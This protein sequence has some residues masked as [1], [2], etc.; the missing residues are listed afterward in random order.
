MNTPIYKKTVLKNGLRYL[1]VPMKSSETVLAMVLVGTGA[2]FETKEQNG[3]AHFLEH[4]CFKGTTKRPTAKGIALELDSIG[5]E[6][7][8]F[9]G[10]SHTGYYARA[11][12][13]HAKKII[14]IVSDIY[15]NSVFPES[16]IKKEQGVVIQEINMYAD[17]P[18]YKVYR[19][20]NEL[21]YGD[22][23]AGREIAGTK[24]TVSSFTRENLIAYH[25][26]QYTAK[27][28][29]V[30]IAG[31]VPEKE[32]KKQV[33]ELFGVL[34][35]GK[36]NKHQKTVVSQK[37]PQVAI[38]FKE[39]DQTH[40]ILSFRAFDFLDKRVQAG[41]TMS[42]VLSAGMSSRL[43]HRMR[44]DL[45]ICYYVYATL[46][47]GFDTGEFSIAAGVA[48]DRVEEAIMEILAVLKKFKEEGVTKEEL[49]KVKEQRL[50][51]L[52]LHLETAEDYANFYGKEEVTKGKAQLPKERAKQAE[53][54]TVQ[55]VNKVAKE[56]LQSS[57][58][59]L[60]IVGPFK[61]ADKL[62]FLKLLKNI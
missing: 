31:N 5:A 32:A 62:R 28:T 27:N 16:E 1:Y 46:N 40:L 60:A 26:S 30:I 11:H 48:N 53:A 37:A 41:R 61:E 38:Q 51:G 44:E 23:P 13:R 15:L 25:T 34:K 4:M 42:G 59:N 24:E 8:A 52:V 45:G 3:L 36:K 39:T 22:Q 10:K 2:D 12:K 6:H 17:D 56:I 57:Q 54:V 19:L 49:A 14:E 18:Q 21:L 29:V 47:N 20:S 55:Q 43:W 7:N 50:S 35:E 58:A 9:T 33:T